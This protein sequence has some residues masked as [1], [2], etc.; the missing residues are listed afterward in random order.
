MFASTS[1]LGWGFH[2]IPDTEW[3]ERGREEGEE[4]RDERIMHGTSH[5]PREE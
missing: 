2:E 4:C 1:V 5:W 3:G